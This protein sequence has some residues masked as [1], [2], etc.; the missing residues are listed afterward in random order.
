MCLVEH[1]D[2]NSLCSLSESGCLD[3][4]LAEEDGGQQDDS[5]D[6]FVPQDVIE[7]AEEYWQQG[8]DDDNESVFQAAE[9]ANED[10]DEDV[11][12][13]EEEQIINNTKPAPPG[14]TPLA[15]GTLRNKISNILRHLSIAKIFPRPGL[16]R[17]VLKLCRYA[18]RRMG[19]YPT[20]KLKKNLLSLQLIIIFLSELGGRVTSWLDNPQCQAGEPG[21]Y[22]R[23]SMV[24]II[25]CDYLDAGDPE[26]MLNVSSN[27]SKHAGRFGDLNFHVNTIATR[28]DL[29]KSQDPVFSMVALGT[30]QKVFPDEQLARLFTD[31]KFS[32]S[33][34]RGHQPQFV[35]TVKDQFI[36]CPVFL[37]GRTP[38][39]QPD[40]DVCRNP[41]RHR[42]ASDQP[43]WGEHHQPMHTAHLTSALGI[44]SCRLGLLK[45][46]T[47]RTFRT[48][49]SFK[50]VLQGSIPAWRLANRMGHTSGNKRLSRMAYAPTYGPVDTR[51]TTA[52]GAHDM[53]FSGHVKDALDVN[54]TVMHLP[55]LEDVEPKLLQKAHSLLESFHA[56]LKVQQEGEHTDVPE[57]IKDGIIDIFRLINSGVKLP[58]KEALAGLL[59]L[60]SANMLPFT[61]VAQ[62]H[63]PFDDDSVRCGSNANLLQ[64]LLRGS[65]HLCPSCNESFHLDQMDN[66]DKKLVK[67][68]EIFNACLKDKHKQFCCFVCSKYFP[69]DDTDHAL[70]CFQKHYDAVSSHNLDFDNICVLLTSSF[71]QWKKA[72]F[73]VY[74]V[75]SCIDQDW[76]TRPDADAKTHLYSTG[77]IN[78]SSIKHSPETGG[79]KFMVSLGYMEF[80]GHLGSHFFE[81]TIVEANDTKKFESSIQLP[82]TLDEKTIVCPVRC[83]HH[84]WNQGSAGK[85]TFVSHLVNDHK[86]PILDT[87]DDNIVEAIS[88]NDKH[89][90]LRLLPYIRPSMTLMTDVEVEHPNPQFDGF[91]AQQSYGALRKKVNEGYKAAYHSRK[92]PPALQSKK[93]KEYRQKRKDFLD[94]KVVEA[95]HVKNNAKKMERY[96]VRKASMTEEEKT[97]KRIK[98][99]DPKIK[100]RKSE[101]TKRY[102]AKKK[103]ARDQAES[104]SVDL[105]EPTCNGTRTEIRTIGSGKGAQGKPDLAVSDGKTIIIRRSR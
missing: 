13:P 77:I 59:A 23:W 37:H 35:F 49:Y 70:E 61:S 15:L 21:R 32:L 81:T 33:L 82:L 83:C 34:L 51:R 6:Q 71:Q 103:A 50:N 31:R 62:Q 101:A 41:I 48:L 27:S 45:S 89:K 52:E 30:A 14:I 94:E 65:S 91:Y 76:H 8:D 96:Y 72:T 25:F 12:D 29:P 88:T 92:A 42:H 90:L 78:W 85:I 18:A 22:L 55:D 17:D 102:N 40:K 58:S 100:K 87:G 11:L 3:P 66:L 98:E 93:R 1:A 79:G 75:A 53:E 97:A 26:F 56:H 60:T 67:A 105:V 10:E 36:D 84:H 80:V 73:F 19:L 64:W 54:G 104:S 4:A 57:T 20:G 7:N 39:R 68:F 5:N 74:P 95:R 99:A 46:I 44:I 38:H 9:D 69:L 28:K 16:R 43:T 24:T 86:F 63:H 2:C 47:S